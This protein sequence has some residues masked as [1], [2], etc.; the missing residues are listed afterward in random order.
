MSRSGS[1]RDLGDI[2]TVQASSTTGTL[3]PLV[4]LPSVGQLHN[5]DG[6]TY[7]SVVK[8]DKKLEEV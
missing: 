6:N 4:I 3:R 7:S 2:S 8:K 1:A 5:L